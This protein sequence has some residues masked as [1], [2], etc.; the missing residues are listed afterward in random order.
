ME[1]VRGVLPIFGRVEAFHEIQSSV[2]F[3]SGLDGSKP[4]YSTVSV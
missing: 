1:I 4:I 3:L 2:D